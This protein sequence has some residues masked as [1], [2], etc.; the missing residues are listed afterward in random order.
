MEGSDKETK[1]KTIPSALGKNFSSK[2]VTTSIADFMGKNVKN[3]IHPDNSKAL[4]STPKPAI[5]LIP[6]RDLFS[7][8]WIC[9]MY[10]F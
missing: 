8:L 6:N 1:S 9:A 5:Y 2:L 10:Q 4:T 3:A 7:K